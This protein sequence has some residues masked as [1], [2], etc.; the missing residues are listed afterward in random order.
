MKDVLKNSNFVKFILAF[1]LVMTIW[2]ISM[3][4][5]G[6]K[7][8]NENN[9][10]T[11]IYP[12]LSLMG[13]ISGLIFANKWGGFKSYIGKTLSLFSFGLL[14]QFFGQAAYAYYI[15]IKGIDV[16]YP[17]IG[18]IG[19]FGSVIFYI[20]AACIL[21]KLSGLTISFQS[22]K[23]KFI[24]LLI[25][26]VVLVV[27]YFLFLQ[28]YE[29]DFANKLKIFLDFGYPLGEA[30]YVSIAVIALLVSSN[31]LGGIMKKPIIFFILALI[32]Q[33]FCDFVFLYQSNHSMW[34]VGG[35]NDY[36]YFASYFLMTLALV[37]IGNTFN[38]IKNS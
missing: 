3:F 37:D 6:L 33:Y 36:M 8:S 7:G 27:S 18:D 38:R 26:L 17:S 32:F 29:F 25:P 20:W 4:F 23:N 13:G 15:Y 30:V 19:Y 35:I 1:Y 12:L 34:Y 2:W 9:Y 16:P 24:V 21:A 14:A 10:F 28:G 22:L 31:F 11:L 5:R